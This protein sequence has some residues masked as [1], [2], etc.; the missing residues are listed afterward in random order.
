MEG[1]P[2]TACDIAGTRLGHLTNP[3][4]RFIM[5]SSS[6]YSDA[7]HLSSLAASAEE[8]ERE[9]YLNEVSQRSTQFGCGA[10][11]YESTFDFNED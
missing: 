5:T 2:P 6:D 8:Q 9:A 4:E 3:I 11:E 1:E 7:K 10:W